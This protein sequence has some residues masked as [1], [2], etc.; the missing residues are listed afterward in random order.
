MI[1]GLGRSSG[2]GNGNPLC[3]SCLGHCTDRGAWQTVVYGVAKSWT[4]LSH[5]LPLFSLHT[6]SGG[7]CVLAC[8]VA[9]VASLCHPL[10]CQSPLSISMG[11]TRQEYWSGLPCPSPGDLPDRGIELAFLQHWQA[12][13]LP[14]SYLGSPFTV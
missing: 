10:N 3:Y 7:R 5:K 2:E 4:W 13:S 1:P 6:A 9:S 12:G 8:W 14:L 11:S